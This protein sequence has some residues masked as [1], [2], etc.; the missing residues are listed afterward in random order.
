MT[1]A[2]SSC[3]LVHPF[4]GKPGMSA[5]VSQIRSTDGSAMPSAVCKLHATRCLIRCVSSL[6]FLNSPFIR[7]PLTRHI[8]LLALCW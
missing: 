3:L 7:T 6:S 2:A 1:P 5:S 8:R 4:P